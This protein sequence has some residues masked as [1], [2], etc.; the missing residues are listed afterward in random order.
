MSI[1]GTLWARCWAWNLAVLIGCAC[2]PL[3]AQIQPVPDAPL[4]TDAPD[5]LRPRVFRPLPCH[6]YHPKKAGSHAPAAVHP[7]LLNIDM[8]ASIARSDTFDIQSYHIE[9]DLTQ[10][11]QQQLRGQATLAFSVLE[12]SADGFWLDLLDLAVDSIHL[13]G[14]LALFD[15][16]DPELRI[17][18]ADPAG[19]Q[20]GANHTVVIWYG[21]H[22]Y[23]D[24]VWG[25]VYFESGYVY[26][27]GI[28]LS[29]IPPNFGKVWYP[30]FDQF[31]ERATYTVAVT[32]DG[33]K[34]AHNQGTMVSETMLGGDTLRRVFQLDHPITTHQSAF[35]VSTYVDS[36][37]VHT[38]NYGDIPVRLTAKPADLAPMA[39]RFQH[40]GY[41][42]DAL[43]HW[44]GPYAWERVG[45]VLTTDGALEIPTNVAYPQFMTGESLSANGG[46]F[47]HELG[48]LWWGDEVAPTVHNHMWLKEGPAEYSSHLFVEWKDGPE[49]FVDAVK[50]NHYFV[51]DQAHA[52]DGDFYPLSPMPDE[53]IYG[54]HTYY[55]GAS[56]MHNLRAYLGDETFRSA[57][58][59]VLNSLA[60]SHMDVALFQETLEGFTGQTLSHFFDAQVLQP[61]FSTWIIDST[62]LVPGI[63]PGLQLFLRQR[64]RATSVY[65]D[66]VPLDVTLWDAQWNRFETTV[67]VGGASDV[68]TVEHP[69]FGPVVMVALNAR[70]RL[71]QA[72]MDH[73]YV[74][75]ETS[76]LEALPWVDLRIGCDAIG[77][78]DSALVRVEHHWV[79][80]DGAVA[81]YIETLSDSH[82]WEIGGVWPAENLLLDA[83]L[84]YVGT[85]WHRL[86]AGLYGAGEE[87][88]MLAWRPSAAE[89]WTLYPDYEWQGGS[90]TNASG[91]F[92][93]LN[94]RPGQ[95]AFARGDVSAAVPDAPALPGMGGGTLA[96]FP[97]PATDRV[98]VP[99][100]EA[101]VQ[102]R[103]VDAAGQIHF[104]QSL[105]ST[106][107]EIPVHAWSAGTYHAVAFDAQGL[108]IGR[109][110][111]V[112]SGRP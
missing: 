70:G 74:I 18:P 60:G 104:N 32:S 77:A 19:W 38:G 2:A 57:S 107:L 78:G 86:D 80:P 28:G 10:D 89:P 68:V 11:E 111:F 44:W 108:P 105:S 13:D 98:T 49:A 42:I 75:S 112:V 59:S 64:L 46:L 8:T 88:A 5:T 66:Q 92:R 7:K 53:V 93:I 6:P 72:R 24:P 4:A 50:D 61:G 34:R 109:G 69:G 27:L 55:K 84:G 51:L 48:H 102:V 99:L 73:T 90:L 39:N 100:P 33:G 87:G 41:A 31:V 81:P 29:T 16:N 20:A 17:H 23:R 52:Q 65:H 110:S 79:A 43:E 40:L 35:A 95:Y 62:A 45:Y 97:S 36:N 96:V 85:E 76:G 26:N 83:R 54:R 37:Y 15:H 106:R 9:L 30:C 3:A 1:P 14:V 47:S 101:A 21:G 12:N 103:V 58:Q 63:N 71:N 25:G 82:Y 22:P 91:Y 56:V 94:L 67:L